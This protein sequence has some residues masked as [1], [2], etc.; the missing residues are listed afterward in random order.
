MS[1]TVPM[2][3][4]KPD[5]EFKAP[6]STGKILPTAVDLPYSWFA[7]ACYTNVSTVQPCMHPVI[8]QSLSSS[9]T[10]CYR[11]LLVTSHKLGKDCKC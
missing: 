6:G 5:G 4:K 1:A 9:V 2:S 11:G 10:G 7:D 3:G 8:P